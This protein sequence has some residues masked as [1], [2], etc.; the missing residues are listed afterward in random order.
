MNDAQQF[1]ARCSD[2]RENYH[3]F[4]GIISAP[5]E[6]VSVSLW[7]FSIIT[8]YRLSSHSVSDWRKVSYE[9]AFVRK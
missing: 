4:K 5:F 6:N 7:I 3:E 9:Y 1:K 8:V 2:Q